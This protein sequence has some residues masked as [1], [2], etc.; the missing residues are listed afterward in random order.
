MMI[1]YALTLVTVVA[2]SGVL[3]AQSFKFSVGYGVPWISQDIGTNSATTYSTTLNPQTNASV[4]RTTNSVEEVRGSFGAGLN[5]SAAFSYTLSENIGV[6]LGISYLSGKEY[7]TNSTYM[8]Y[9]FDQLATFSHEAETSKSKGIL[10]TPT[11]KFI[12][13][14]RIFTP[15]FLAGPV[16]G[17]L[18]FRKELERYRDENGTVATEFRTTRFTGG[19]AIG[20]RGAVGVS[21]IISKKLSLFS[22]LV[23]TGMNYYPKESEITRY[24]INGE[25]K[26]DQL[27]TNV[28]KTV[29]VDKVVNDSQSTDDNSPNRSVRVHVAM[30]SMSANL[31]VILSLK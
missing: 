15:Y 1:K 18:N 8:D 16:F 30:S 22:E 11:L 21:I 29:F 9:Q 5:A 25:N 26:I 19:V 2:F 28:R 17:K 13:Q 27:T 31:G 12:T 10:F 23:F 6:E 14:Q 20:L 4:R 7:S 3:Q 24:V